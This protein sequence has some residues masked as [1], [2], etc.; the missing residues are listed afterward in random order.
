MDESAPT[1]TTE[2]LLLNLLQRLST[3]GEQ[4]EVTQR[5]LA[6]AIATP[7]VPQPTRQKESLPKLS[8]FSGMRNEYEGWVIEARS[9]IQSDGGAI[10]TP[11]AQMR[12]IFACLEGDARNLCTAWTTA[13]LADGTGEEL[14]SYLDS[15][16]KDP[17]RERTAMQKLTQ[18]RQGERESF[19]KFLPRFETELANAGA[20]GYDD[21]VKISWLDNTLSPLLKS[22]LVT[23][24]PVPHT[25]NEYISLLLVISSRQE[26]LLPSRKSTLFLDKGRMPTY[27]DLMDW[28]PTATTTTSN[29]TKNYQVQRRATWVPKQTIE[30]RKE[31]GLCF[32]CGNL[33]HRVEG[34]KLLPA[35]R[36]LQTYSSK[37]AKSKGIDEGLAK[38][39]MIEEISEIGSDS[40]ASNKDAGKE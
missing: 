3:Q 37:T 8:T 20:L 38:P 36:P 32:R 7:I 19:A 23:V 21:R 18:M 33:G 16:F 26:A 10:G 5:L 24:Y 35:R 2:Q 17:N 25:Y 27:S 28:E 13:N 22:V 31:K 9:K 6:Q 39:D 11:Q 40:E 34:C 12:Y 4:Q 29:Q 14:L 30:Y 1:P 15:I